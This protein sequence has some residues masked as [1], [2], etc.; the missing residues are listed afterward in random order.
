MNKKVYFAASIRGGRSDEQLYRDLI[1]YIK[2]TDKVLTEH[3]GDLSISVHE[4]TMNSDRKIYEQDMAWLRESDLVIA[5]CTTASLGVGYELAFAEKLGKPCHVLYRPETASLS[6]MIK[7][8]E[9]FQ[10]YPYGT[11]DEACRI[12]DEVLK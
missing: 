7:G 5:E 4:G 10:I 3:I 1:R 9:Y 6:A 11:F 2:K 12:I 8:N